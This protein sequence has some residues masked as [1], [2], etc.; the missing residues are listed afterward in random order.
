ML[1]RGGIALAFA[2]ALVAFV[3]A[4]SSS[5]SSSSS[6]VG[7]T[8]SCTINSNCNPPLLHA[9]STGTVARISEPSRTS[10]RRSPRLPPEERDARDARQGGS[11]VERHGGPPRAP[12][13]SGEQPRG[14]RRDPDDEVVGAV[15]ATS[16]RRRHQIAYQGL[17]YGLGQPVEDA[18]NHEERPDRPGP[19]PGRADG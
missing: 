2:S 12:Q 5:C 4:G 18:V 9:L 7:L 19:D 11:D 13:G 17:L 14:E 16:R 10:A 6:G 1:H 3:V 8:D 15:G